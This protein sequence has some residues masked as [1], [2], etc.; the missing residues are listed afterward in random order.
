MKHI[1]HI[2]NF[3][4]Q[5]LK[6]LKT[7]RSIPAV[8]RDIPVIALCHPDWIGVRTSTEM[9]FDNVAYA[10]EIPAI[11]A[12][13]IARVLLE[14]NPECIVF[15]GFPI[16]YEKLV[17]ELRSQRPG[18]RLC[19]LWHGSFEHA[20][21]D[22]SWRQHRI[23]WELCRSGHLDKWGFVKKGLAEQ[24][25]RQGIRAE[26]VMN[27]VRPEKLT[28]LV[29]P[30]QK[31]HGRVRIGVFA[32]SKLP[33]KNQFTQLA[34]CS[35]VPK[36]TVEVLPGSKR[37]EDFASAFGL[38]LINHGEIPL[39]KPQFIN[40]LGNMDVNLYVTF[41]ECAPMIPLESYALGVPCLT[42]CNHHYFE[43]FPD[44]REA[45]VVK[46]PDDASHI[47]AKL[48][49]VLENKKELGVK[50]RRFIDRNEKLAAKSVERFVYE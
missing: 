20:A 48:L 49:H 3:F 40:L 27:R 29:K 10:R 14:S 50:L 17:Q 23:I 11:Y 18:V 43:E 39:P 33:K 2:V 42:G 45:L 13:I 37:V 38:V 35:K 34:A 32:S 15:S 31:E 8:K 26:F 25:T 28:H 21:E 4:P 24:Y 19:V 36:A 7:M 46:R 6:N 5:Y 22:Y 12:R 30:L 1:K 47:T 16:G 44:L 41:A 9:L